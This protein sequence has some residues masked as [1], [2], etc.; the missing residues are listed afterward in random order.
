MDLVPALLLVTLVAYYPAWHG[1]LLWDDD[2]HITRVDL[3]SFEGLWRIWFD[4]GA[5]QQHYP[6]THSAFWVLYRLFG[7][8]TLGYHLVNISLHATSAALRRHSPET[9]CARRR[10]GGIH[11]RPASGACGIGG[12]D[13]RAEK[14]SRA[15]S[16][17]ARPWPICDSTRID[18]GN[19]M[20]W[21]LSSSR[22]PC[23]ARR[24]R[25]RCPQLFS[26]CSGGNAAALRWRQDVLPLAPFFALG[27]IGGAVTAWV[28]RTHIGAD[29]AA[30]G[31][32]IIERSPIAG[33]AIWFYLS[34]LVWP[35]NLVFIYPRWTIDSLAW[36]Q[37]LFPLATGLLLAGLWY[38][39]RSRAP[40][41]ATLL[42]IGT[43]APALGFVNVYPF[44]FLRG[45]PFSAPPA[46]ES[47]RSCRQARRC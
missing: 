20:R 29:G 46:S 21:R 43:L 17:S 28:E 37:Y 3:R 23:S 39:T 41:A 38:R 12:V 31:F 25:P 9:G 32:S 44:V 13:H 6:V 24:S 22:L 30:F 10:A 26:S 45:R 5:T 16:I 15:C 11:L 1:G 42:F 35:S 33:R 27:L 36:W 19:R 4:V 7:D 2:A 8:A 14:H 40:L 34:K 18:G 47:S